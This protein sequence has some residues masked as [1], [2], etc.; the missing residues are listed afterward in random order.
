VILGYQTGKQLMALSGH[1]S[2]IMTVVFSEQMDR[3]ASASVDGTAKIW[4]AQSG[5]E[6]LTLNDHHDA[7]LGAAFSPDGSL[8]ATAGDD[9]T[10][11]IDFLKVQDLIDLAKTRLTRGLS[12]S[13]CQ[14]YLHAETC[15]TI[16]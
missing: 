10:V 14:Q 2:T 11:R 7:V 1:T 8:L 5:E 15:P 12:T 16:P 6:L 3:L 9:S 13:E 4:D